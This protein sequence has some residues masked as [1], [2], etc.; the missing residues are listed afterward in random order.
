MKKQI[1]ITALSVALLSVGAMAFADNT[2]LGTVTPNTTSADMTTKIQCVGTAVAARETALDTAMTAYTGSANSAYSA[3]ATALVSA[4]QQTTA[5]AV[6][7][8]VRT[9]WTAFTSS[10]KTARK[11][12]QTARM[13][14]WSTFRTAAK[15]CKAPSS[16]SDSGNSGSEASGN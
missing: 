15:A 1:I 14:A 9:A 10:M 11:T 3:R 6:K 12:W 2:T 7:A 8:A 5:V 13:S 4:Y 16:V